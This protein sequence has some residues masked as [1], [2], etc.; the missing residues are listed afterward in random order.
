YYLFPGG[1]VSQ[2]SIVAGL[3][4]PS[5]SVDKSFGSVV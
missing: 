3:E 5:G 2:G 4:V 1:P